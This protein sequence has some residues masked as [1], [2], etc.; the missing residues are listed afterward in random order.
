MRRFLISL[1]IVLL[2]SV[3]G[4]AQSAFWIGQTT[5]PVSGG[6]S[7]SCA[8]LG[9]L[10]CVNGWTQFAVGSAANPGA[11]GEGTGYS[12]TGTRIIYVSFSTGCDFNGTTCTNNGSFSQPSKTPLFAEG[13][14]RNGS[15]DWMLLACGD[16]F[17]D[18]AFGNVVN[19]AGPDSSHPLLFAEYDPGASH[20]PPDPHPS[21]CS[22]RP[23]LKLSSAWFPSGPVFTTF[24]SSSNKINNFALVGIEAYCYTRDTGNG[25]FSLADANTLEQGISIG[26]TT[27]SALLEDNKVSFCGENGINP[28]DPYTPSLINLFVRRNEFLSNYGPNGN[29]TEG[30]IVGKI[31]NGPA[32]YV[33]FEN[34]IDHNGWAQ[35]INGVTWATQN[36]GFV[37]NIY[38]QDYGT[39][40]VDPASLST[41]F[42][43]V[44]NI[45]AQGPTGSNQLRTGGSQLTGNLFMQEPNF[46]MSGTNELPGV[47][48]NWSGNV[49]VGSYPLPGGAITAIGVGAR[50]IGGSALSYASAPMTISN[51]FAVNSPADTNAGSQGIAIGDNNGALQGGQT[52]V[53]ING[54]VIFGYAQKSANGV[55]SGP[56]GGLLTQHPSTPGTGYTD[57][58]I[59]VSSTCPSDSVGASCPNANPATVSQHYI[60]ATVPAS[61]IGVEGNCYYQMTSGSDLTLHG[62]V[63]CN[64][65]SATTVELYPSNWNGSTTGF[66]YYPYYATTVTTTGSHCTAV[67]TADIISVNGSIV[68]AGLGGA[69]APTE[70]P[71]NPGG[72]CQAGDHVTVANGA[73]CFNQTSCSGGFSP[74][75][76]TGMQI[77][78]DTVTSNTISTSGC[79]I[80]IN[81]IVDVAGMNSC[82]FTDPG[83]TAGS[84]YASG[85]SGSWTPS[86]NST[87][88]GSVTSGILTV[89]GWS[90][91]PLQLGDALTWSGVHPAD[92][93]KTYAGGTIASFGSPTASACTTFPS[94]CSSNV[95]PSVPLVYAPGHSGSG[96]GATA[97][98]SVDNGK[99]S[100][101]QLTAQGSS[102]T[103]GDVLSVAPSSIGGSG[104][105]TNFSITVT[106]AASFIFSF[107]TPSSSVCTGGG[108]TAN[109]TGTYNGVTLI[110][111][112]G[113]T[114]TANV[115]VTS[116][117]VSSVAFVSSTPGFYINDVLTAAASSIGGLANT[118]AGNTVYSPAPT[119]GNANFTVSPA[120][121]AAGT[122][123][124]CGTGVP[125]TG[126]GG[127]GTYAL[128]NLNPTVGGGTSMSS[129]S[130]Q[131]LINLMRNQF[132]GNWKTAL[133]ACATNT[134]IKQGFGYTDTC[135]P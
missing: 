45:V 52:A 39:N 91:N 94:G 8:T 61:D 93:I 83:R 62:P 110:G 132:K 129:Y 1:I 55:T 42:N 49:M 90:G 131:Q 96:T 124:S 48:P 121:F 88:T 2:C 38:L 119:I 81:N 11:F 100:G 32:G 16:T 14:L 60:V 9:N 59:A 24:G 128:T 85:G 89:S 102:Y 78:L 107:G 73:T 69:D 87:F 72:G 74:A 67:P 106:G 13:E 28:P 54:N 125:C 51:N 113:A 36:T 26:F 47:S 5:A 19:L 122:A 3:I 75:G 37:H 58:K 76:G 104:G 33:V 133:T 15:P 130:A 70:I 118:G 35:A 25:S 46:N 103:A 111:P 126:N 99:V 135:T 84:Y 79:N 63:N 68:F 27:D 109:T 112:H 65:T 22:A 114:A 44:G 98:I 20:N 29:P 30:F 10:T 7:S 23:L 34:T 71:N 41:A 80:T 117:A 12:G 101:F 127:N 66:I 116:G 92:Y 18:A 97:N 123:N 77:V 95:F 43:L 40:G 31:S 4:P 57:L 53:T 105:A 56:D 50:G 120:T 108:C 115:T 82:T 86:A 64:A 17:L 6:G 134:Y 21:T